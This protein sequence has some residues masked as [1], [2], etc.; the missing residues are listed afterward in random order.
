[1]ADE[2]P[3]FSPVAELN[4]D[5][6]CS[7]MGIQGR[8]VIVT[9]AHQGRDWSEALIW[10][11]TTDERNVVRSPEPGGRY[12]F[13]AASKAILTLW[14]SATQSID[15][16][17]PSPLGG[18]AKVG[19]HRPV[20]KSVP[21]NE[22]VM[23]DSVGQA[24]V[25]TLV[26]PWNSGTDLHQIALAHL[27]QETLRIDMENLGAGRI[28][29]TSYLKDNTYMQDPED[30]SSPY[31]NEHEAPSDFFKTISDHLV[32]LS[33]SGRLTYYLS[34]ESGSQGTESI[35][36]YVQYGDE[37]GRILG[38]Q[39]FPFI[40]PFSGI[41]GSVSVAGDLFVWR[42]EQ[43]VCSSGGENSNVGPVDMVG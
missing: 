31:G 5:H 28:W 33:S 17:L 11:W 2:I 10:D 19:N 20:P 38:D 3:Q 4:T 9:L 7:G 6:F 12:W 36:Y 41:V 32:D 26:D 43:A 14:D 39:H 21:S 15:V 13:M 1:M 37:P 30:A 29:F 27:D 34:P 42:L 24:L 16:H 40:C 18:Y 22:E 25:P 23:S 8:N 35:S